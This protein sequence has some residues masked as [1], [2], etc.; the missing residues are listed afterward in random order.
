MYQHRGKPTLQNKNHFFS[1]VF[2]DAKGET[3]QRQQRNTTHNR[4]A[5]PFPNRP[6]PHPRL[7]QLIPQP[8]NIPPRKPT[9]P[10]LHARHQLQPLHL[11]TLFHNRPHIPIKQLLLPIQLPKQLFARAPRVEAALFGPELGFVDLH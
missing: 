6:N 11:I 1:L 5:S 8:L 4:I 10:P 2:F 3:Q 9:P 7:P